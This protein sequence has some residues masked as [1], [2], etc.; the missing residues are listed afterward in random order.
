MRAWRLRCRIRPA[1]TPPLLTRKRLRYSDA[2]TSRQSPNRIEFAPA[3]GGLRTDIP[4]PPDSTN[5]R[6][7]AGLVR[8]TGGQRTRYRKVLRCALLRGQEAPDSRRGMQ[9]EASIDIAKIKTRQVGDATE[10]IPQST[11]VNM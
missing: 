5:H 2:A 4:I 9:I 8:V 11:S 3:P 1:L 10:L 6:R 7:G